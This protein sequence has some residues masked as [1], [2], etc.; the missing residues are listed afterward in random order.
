MPYT[1]SSSSSNEKYIQRSFVPTYHFQPS[2]PRLPIP[3]LEDTCRRYLDCQKVILSPEE[4][5]NTK[6]LVEN[7]KQHE[8]PGTILDISINITIIVN[9]YNYHQTI[10]INIST[11]TSTITISSFV[12]TI[13]SMNY[14]T[15]S[16]SPI[17]SYQ[18]SCYHTLAPFPVYRKPPIIS[19]PIIS[20]PR[21]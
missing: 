10:I 7:F 15:I 16:M 4:Y 12:T 19:P 8:G 21:V 14:Y 3:K 9:L 6:R 13:I 1:Y 17:S 5:E 11:I 2:L 20:P 18:Q